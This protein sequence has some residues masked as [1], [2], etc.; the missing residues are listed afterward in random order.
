VMVLSPLQ[1]NAERA[2]KNLIF[3]LIAFTNFL[4]SWARTSDNRA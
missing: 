1:P 2:L 3:I 4:S